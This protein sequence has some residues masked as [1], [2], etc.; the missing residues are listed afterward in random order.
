MFPPRLHT[1]IRVDPAKGNTGQ[2]VQE[3]EME[4]DRENEKKKKGQEKKEIGKDGEP[5]EKES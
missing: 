2:E 3:E 1:I 5:E 4:M